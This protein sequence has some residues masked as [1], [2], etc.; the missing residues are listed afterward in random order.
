MENDYE[1]EIWPMISSEAIDH[2][3]EKSLVEYN[4]SGWNIQAWNNQKKCSLNQF[5]LKEQKSSEVYL[6]SS[7]G[8]LNQDQVSECMI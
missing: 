5:D 1:S 6:K 4:S 8:L 7:S 2:L 3:Y